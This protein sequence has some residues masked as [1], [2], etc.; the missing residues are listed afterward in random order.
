MMFGFETNEYALAAED[1]EPSTGNTGVLYDEAI[2]S[3][4]ESHYSSPVYDQ[5]GPDES[6]G[7]PSPKPTA[8]AQNQA[9]F[10]NA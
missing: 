4:L 6:F 10:S 7:F 8:S 2:Q 3:P 1:L 5:A 9:P